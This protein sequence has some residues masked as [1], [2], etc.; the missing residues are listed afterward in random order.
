[1]HDDI[2]DIMRKILALDL[3]ETA[4]RYNWVVKP[5]GSIM[6]YFCTIDIERDIDSPV[7]ARLMMV[8]GWQAFHNLVGLHV[9]KMFG[10]Y[11][12]PICLPHYEM[13][14][15]HGVDPVLYK[16]D[17]GYKPRTELTEYEKGI[18]RKILWEC[19]GIMMRMETNVKLPLQY[20]AENS[21]FGRVE[22]APGKWQDMP[23][24]I[25][26]PANT[27]ENI[28]FDEK[29]LNAV[30]ELP[31]DKNWKLEFTFSMHPNMIITTGLPR[32]CH[33]ICAVDADNGEVVIDY[34]MVIEQDQ[35]I[36]DL[37]ERMPAIV[38]ASFLTLKRVPAEIKVGNARVF[39]F[40]RSIC[41]HLP[42]K[43][44]MHDSLPKLDDYMKRVYKGM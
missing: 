39:R 7:K 42:I 44:S 15:C 12:S 27:T 18:A 21:M 28:T 31:V 26:K 22:V 29:I 6:P 38:V 13:F 1:M 2:S 40:L 41:L 23:V 14:I 43:L 24:P 20:I 10:V 19:Y 5:H 32:Y 30:K 3:L 16:C 25:P 34:R 4:S 17:E 37:W 33:S 11:E 9:D 8:E 36:K 35:K